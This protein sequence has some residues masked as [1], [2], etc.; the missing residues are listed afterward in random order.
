MSGIVHKQHSPEAL[1][2]CIVEQRA[3]GQVETEASIVVQPSTSHWPFVL[4]MNAL[5]DADIARWLRTRRSV[6][7]ALAATGAAVSIAARPTPPTVLFSAV[8]A[9]PRLAPPPPWPSRA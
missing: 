6:T 5:I 3:D 9:P 2:R 4:R 1:Q 8:N 7:V